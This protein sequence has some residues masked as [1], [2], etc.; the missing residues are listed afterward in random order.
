MLERFAKE[1]DRPGMSVYQCVGTLQPGAQRRAKN[2]VA[3][4][5]ALHVDIDLRML[6]TPPEEVRRKLSELSLSL[7]VEIRNSGGGYHVIAKL[8][9]PVRAGTPEF[10]RANKVRGALTRMLCGDPAPDHEAALLRK[11]GTHNTKYGE[12]RLCQVEKAGAP[13]DIADL[14]AFV[15]EMPF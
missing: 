10:E 13:V 8:K 1:Y 11:V 2:T 12:P 6:A 4:L 14:E 15:E 9:E 3:E 7:P 5:T